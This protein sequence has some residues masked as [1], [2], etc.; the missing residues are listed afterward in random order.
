MGIPRLEKVLRGYLEDVRPAL[1]GR[2]LGRL[3]R[4]I[5]PRPPFVFVNAHHTGSRR[6]LRAGL[7]LSPKTIFQ[8]VRRAVAP[9]IGRPVHPHMLRHSFASRPRENGADL[10]LIQE[11]LGHAQIS[12]T[13]MYAHLTTTR[14]RQELAR[15]LE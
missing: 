6:V 9:I 10:Q 7:A 8:L 5:P 13:V 14:Q 15:L 3:V 11:A 1:V 12:T 4:A 2:P